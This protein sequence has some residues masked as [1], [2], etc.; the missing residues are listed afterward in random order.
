VETGEVLL[1]ALGR[2]PDEQDGAWLLRLTQLVTA[3]PSAGPELARVYADTSVDEAVRFAAFYG[4]EILIRRGKDYSRF[5]EVLRRDGAQFAGRPMYLCISA[6]ADQLGSDRVSD[7]RLAL[8]KA[9]RALERMPANFVVQNQVAEY[10]ARL[11]ER[12]PVS[13]DDLLRALSLARDAAYASGYA[14]YYQTLALAELAC[15]NYQAAREAIGSAID[16]EPSAG[17]NYALRIGD[18]NVV[19]VKIDVA[20]SVKEVRTLHSNAA[21]EMRLL[22][23]DMTQLLGILAAVIALISLTGQLATRVEFHDAAP[24]LATAAGAVL[25]I[26]GGLSY[27]IGGR[28]RQRER[29]VAMIAGVLLLVLPSI[30]RAVFV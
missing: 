8:S 17:T 21:E 28:T 1:D 9:E 11:A 5:R 13:E 24:L 10:M 19:R 29:L 15:G 26:F 25:F 7:I 30:A 14:R 16:L 27:L 18:Y 6:L 12:A 2:L 3:T 20:E 4:Y 23:S 22:R